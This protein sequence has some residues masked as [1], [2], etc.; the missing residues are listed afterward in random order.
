MKIID[1]IKYQ[2]AKIQQGL[3]TAIKSLKPLLILA[4][5]AGLFGSGYLLGSR[6]FE[7]GNAS[8]IKGANVFFSGVCTLVST[9]SDRLPALQNDQVQIVSFDLDKNSMTGI[10]TL[11]REEIL[12]DLNKTSYTALPLLSKWGELP[13]KPPALTAAQVVKKQDASWK[14]LDKQT[15]LISG[16]CRDINGKEI[17]P[18]LLRE[19]VDVTSVFQPAQVIDDEDFNLTAIRVLDKQSIICNSKSIKYEIYDPSNDV[20]E[21]A[22]DEAIDYTGRIV[23][24]DSKC[25]PDP[26]YLKERPID[27]KT[28]KPMG[29]V[30]K[31]YNLLNTPTQILVYKEND[32]KQIIYLEGKIVDRSEPDAYGKKVICDAREE[33]LV[34]KLVDANSTLV[35]QKGQN[36]NPTEL[37]QNIDIVTEGEDPVVPKQQQPTPKIDENQGVQQL[38]QELDK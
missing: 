11:T 8:R 1:T 29:K 27:P 5:I 7:T 9:G 31:F 10:I 23:K 36:I 4:V 17:S 38:L 14:R 2:L 12:C 13:V 24:V 32:K 26:K 18:N 35:N 15:L 34:V 22:V 16:T 28:K 33:A 3:V 37:P 20:Q 6:S 30:P 25:R 21:V 19:K